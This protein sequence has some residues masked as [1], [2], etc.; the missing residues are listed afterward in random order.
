MIQDN[1]MVINNWNFSKLS[2]QR[3]GYLTIPFMPDNVVWNFNL[4]YSNIAA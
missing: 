3:R 2:L 1:P 4:N